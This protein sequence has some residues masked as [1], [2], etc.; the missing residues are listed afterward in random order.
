VQS[1]DRAVVIGRN[2]NLRL[3]FGIMKTIPCPPHFSYKTTASLPGL[4][5]GRGLYTHH[6][7]K[8]HFH[9][10]YVIQIVEEGVCEGHCLRQSFRVSSREV[11]VIN[12]GE[13]H[14]GSSYESGTLLYRS[15]Y[16]S[17]DFVR[18][19][20]ADL[21]FNPDLEA[22]FIGLSFD[23]PDI[24]LKIKY[25]FECLENENT[26]FALDAA[27]R[28][29]FEVLLRRHANGFFKRPDNPSVATAQTA[30]R[31][32]KDYLR[33]NYTGTFTLRELSCCAG[34]SPTHLSRL[35]RAKTSLSPWQYL[36]NYRIERAKALL[37]SG[38]TVTDAAYHT[39][40]FDPSHF[41]RHFRR[42]TGVAPG[43]FKI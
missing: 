24:L 1:S 11:L 4:A 20:L 6:R 41:S 18:K 13:V 28:S 14:T 38:V 32:A 36:L 12:P 10:H 21:E 39:G 17:P 29:L 31:K 3:V 33:D 25:L 35:F 30:V 7:F 40:F 19:M 16:P 37:A 34:I 15:L 43:N 42:I 27:A 2:L 22:Y 8:P 9:E 5:F 26:A 23:D